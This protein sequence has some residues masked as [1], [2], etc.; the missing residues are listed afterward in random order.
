MGV[1]PNYRRT[2]WRVLSKGVVDWIHVQIAL[3]TAVRIQGGGR[4]RCGEDLWAFKHVPCLSRLKLSSRAK[5][6]VLELFVYSRAAAEKI[7][8]LAS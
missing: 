6:A 5:D 3:T 7:S 2:R 1:H 4:V 8:C